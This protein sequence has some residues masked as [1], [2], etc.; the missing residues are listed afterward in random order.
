LYSTSNMQVYCGFRG[1]VSYWTDIVTPTPSANS[2]VQPTVPNNTAYPSI[3]APIGVRFFAG[4]IGFHVEAALGTPYFIEGG[5][6]F[7]I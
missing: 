5:L 3:Q 1:G 7:R 4:P 6:T 2:T